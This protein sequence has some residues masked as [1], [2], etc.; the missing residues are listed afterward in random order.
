MS[1]PACSRNCV[2]EWTP[3]APK[4]ELR[5]DV[6]VISICNS[7]R[8]GIKVLPTCSSFYNGRVQRENQAT[9]LCLLHGVVVRVFAH[10]CILLFSVTQFLQN[11]GFKVVSY[12]CKTI[13]KI[14]SLKVILTSPPNPI[15]C[16]T[17]LI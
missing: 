8:Q 9:K 1:L 6:C 4:G 14:A 12:E 3:L 16:S 17:F 13:T 7:I 5:L 15:F 11:L 10:E 2:G